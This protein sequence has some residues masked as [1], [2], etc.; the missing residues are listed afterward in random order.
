MR[1]LRRVG[2][3]PGLSHTMMSLTFFVRTNL[4]MRPEVCGCSDQHDV[5]NE[6]IGKVWI[7]R[8]VIFIATIDYRQVLL[9]SSIRDC[10]AEMRCGVTLL[11]QGHSESL[12]LVVQD[13]QMRSLYASFRNL[14]P[15]AVLGSRKVSSCNPP[16]SLQFW[17]TSFTI[18]CRIPAVGWTMLTYCCSR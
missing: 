5:A 12:R 2:G 17:R 3:W 7:D 10:S 11:K 6:A 8:R 9:S 1:K 14:L 18:Y 16:N 15:K 4:R 13:E